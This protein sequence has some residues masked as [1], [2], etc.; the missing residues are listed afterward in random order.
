MH[1]TLYETKQIRKRQWILKST[2]C[3]KLGNVFYLKHSIC[4]MTWLSCIKED[5][6]INMF[7]LSEWNKVDQWSMEFCKEVISS[8]SFAIQVSLIFASQQDPVQTPSL[9]SQMSSPTPQPWPKAEDGK[10][11]SGRGNSVCKGWTKVVKGQSVPRVGRSLVQW[12]LTGYEVTQLMARVFC[13]RQARVLVNG[14]EGDVS[15]FPP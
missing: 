10:N 4:A 14:E 7:Q 2:L 13:H 9:E 11:I 8:R 12:E 6:L 5:Y 3:E 15:R 1:A